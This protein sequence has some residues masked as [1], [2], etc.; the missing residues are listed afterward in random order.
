MKLRKKCYDCEGRF[1]CKES[2]ETNWKDCRGKSYLKDRLYNPKLMKA[3]LE[4][5][6]EV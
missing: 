5:S 1:R 3:L 6:V 4:N 2:S